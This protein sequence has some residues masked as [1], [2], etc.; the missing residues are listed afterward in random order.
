MARLGPKQ[1]VCFDMTSFKSPCRQ[2][3]LARWTRGRI[4]LQLHINSQSSEAVER[5]NKN[6]QANKF[7]KEMYGEAGAAA[8]VKEAAKVVT[9]PKVAA[10]AKGKAGAKAMPP[11]S[12][13]FKRDEQGSTQTG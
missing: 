4:S 7:L 9:K 8:V 5:E 11:L 3:W 1:A 2:L 12:Y 10:K 13:M 6:V